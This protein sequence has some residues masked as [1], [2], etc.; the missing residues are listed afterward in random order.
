MARSTIFRARPALDP[1]IWKPL[2]RAYALAYLYSAGPRAVNVVIASWRKDSRTKPSSSLLQI[3]RKAVGLNQFPA[4]CGA[5]IGGFTILQIP[6]GRLLSILQH[7]LNRS[8]TRFIP[9]QQKRFVA[10][11]SALLAAWYGFSLLN[12]DQDLDRGR[13]NGGN[14]PAVDSDDR[15]RSCS[16]SPS[17]QKAHRGDPSLAGKTMDLTLFTVTRAVDIVVGE[18]WSRRKS[19]R[20]AAGKWTRLESFV[21]NMVDAGVF[22]LS[23]SIVMWS[24]FYRPDRLPRSYN[25][26]IREAAQVDDRLLEALRR[27]RRGE[28]VYGKDTGQAPMLQ[29]MC[30][31]YQW[32]LDWGDPS[33]VIPIP[34]EMVH[35]GVGPSCEKHAASRFTKA[36]KFAM[37]T[38]LPLNLIVRGR[39]PSVKAFQQALTDSI[40]SSAFL[41]T[42]ICLFYYSVCLSRTRLGPKL[43]SPSVISPQMWDSGLDVGAGCTMCGWSI[44]IEA[45]QRRPEVAFFVAPRAAAT[46]FPRRYNREVGL[47]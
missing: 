33:K 14:G 4:F 16:Q 2:L 6:L 10:F 9:S 13:E 43:F 8:R 38:Y 31:E 5:L 15:R 46:F 44:L 11:V 28:F 30:K 18:L 22:A 47:I 35:M 7:S 24:W 20:T 41:G 27:A 25:K 29:S 19:R 23:A 1:A 42:F 36:F 26:W 32:P 21:G 40:R 12:A 34:C 3:L 39:S 37:A 17:S 45:P